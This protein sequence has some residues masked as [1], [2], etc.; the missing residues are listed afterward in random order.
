[1]VLRP[2]S[3]LVFTLIAQARFRRL[4]VILIPKDYVLLGR[5]VLNRRPWSTRPR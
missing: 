1:M 4:K 3:E 5:D 2:A